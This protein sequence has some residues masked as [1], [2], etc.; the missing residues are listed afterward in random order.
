M[1]QHSYGEEKGIVIKVVVDGL[2][3]QEETI[4]IFSLHFSH[5]VHIT[6]LVEIKE[7]ETSDNLR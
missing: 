6:I 7:R 1:T 2:D 5:D 4:F 3:S